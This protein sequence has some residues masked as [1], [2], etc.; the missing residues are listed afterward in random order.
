MTGTYREQSGVAVTADGARIVYEIDGPPDAPALIFSN[1]LGTDLHMWDPQVGPLTQHFRV[2]RYDARGHGRSDAPAGPYSLEQLAS[3]LLTILDTVQVQQANICGLSLGGQVTLW[4][5]A[6]RPDRIYRAVCANTAA[7]IGVESMWNERIERVRTGGMS[8]IRD[9]GVARF[10]SESFRHEHPQTAQWLGDMLLAT[11]PNG[12]IAACQAVR[13]A[14]L[15]GDVTRITS[16]VLIIGSTLDE[17]TPASQAHDLHQS[18]PGSR[19]VVLDRAAHLSNIE[20]PEAFTS[21]LLAFL[22]E[23]D[24]TG[25]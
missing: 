21:H 24:T 12:Y 10:L 14:D 25:K 6:H 1:S 13:D 17:S 22:L 16:P 2:I 5:L 23:R 18:I 3:D 4:L 8:A 11:P 19:L 15:R 20:Q 7:K 9:A